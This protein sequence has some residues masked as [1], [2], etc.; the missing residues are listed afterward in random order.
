MRLA[1][2]VFN[3]YR[4]DCLVI[5]NDIHCPQM[6]SPADFWQLLI[7][8]LVLLLSGICLFII[9]MFLIQSLEKMHPE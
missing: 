8:L 6:M 7:S 4:M 3:N 9:E 1:S 5:L 2:C